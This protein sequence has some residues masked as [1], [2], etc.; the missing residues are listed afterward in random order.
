MKIKGLFI[1][2]F[3][4]ITSFIYADSTPIPQENYTVQDYSSDNTNHPVAHA[5]DNDTTSWWALYN[6]N[7]FS[8]PGIVEINLG[9]S[10]D[11]SGFS[12]LPNPA[13]SNDKAIGYEIYVSEDGI[14]WGNIQ[15]TGDFTWSSSSDVS[16]KHI[17]FGA[18]TGQYVKV[19]YTSSQNTGNNNIHTGDLFIYESD[20]PATGQINQ[21]LIFDPISKKY[22]TDTP[23]ELNASTNSGLDINFNVVSGPATVSGNIVTLGGT[24]GIVVIR[25]EQAGDETYYSAESFQSF[26]VIDLS[27]F[28]PII[29][30]RLTEDY[31]IEMPESH[32]FP[33]Y[34]G[35]SIEESQVL[36]ISSV[37]VEVEGTIYPAFNGGGYYYALWTP[38]ATGDYSV[39]ITAAASNG[40]ESTI[41]KN[42]T[43]SDVVES[44][45]V[46]TM[47]DVVIEF[48]G[49]NSRW[50]TGTY[51]MPQHIGSYDQIMAN[52]TIECP[53]GNCDDWDRQAYIDVKGP[54]GNWI[55]IIRYITPYGVACNHQV[56]VTDYAS[57]LQGEFEIRMF[58]DT[59]GT[60]GWQVTLDFD[61]QQGSPQ[62]L[63]SI[64][65][66]IWD[67]T[68]DLGNPTNLQPV[69]TVTYN[70]N[71]TILSSHMRLSTT[72]HGWGSNNSQNAAEFY[73]A[74][75]YIDIDGNQEYVQDL[76][77]D[78]NPNPDNCTG[79]QGTWQYDRAGWCPGII[80][81]PNIIDLA[82][83]INS[84]TVDLT[85]RFDPTYIDYCH[86]N[87]P[88]CVSGSTCPD[89]NDGY[90]A[91]YLIDGQIVNF[92]NSP[93]LQD[94]TG[95]E[96]V[97][98][99]LIY[100]LE[101]YPNPSSG[102]F[103]VNTSNLKGE[104]RVY[105]QKI[106][107]EV[108]KT[109]YFN[110]S[111]ELNG[112]LFDISNKSTGMYFISIEN[113]SGTGVAKLVVK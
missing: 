39:N 88:D 23:F 52:L 2:M 28:Y 59:W 93:L 35:T 94:V 110:N 24:A 78:C 21:L 103:N 11:V 64:V 30:T 111:Q 73:H 57:L 18:I 29:T 101:V 66:E 76:W 82:G 49:T 53:A 20:V 60:G 83:F 81:P 47:Q 13:N 40:N 108:I 102:R 79:Q 62:F 26:E 15:T 41:T 104:C 37:D 100:D 34:I 19:V 105:I 106:S 38:S 12:Y 10:Y 67:G 43:V 27:T 1:L 16:R 113:K 8:L 7:G 75:N 42:I 89:C 46:V 98:N 4:F 86:P 95:I 70:F 9:A 5:F 97:D 90:K 36:S 33:I 3:I 32:A 45:N 6:A 14:N 69:D 22:T 109:Y 85:Y 44:Q 107:G 61:H 54:D 65:D 80:A 48:G 92:S 31:P 77:N 58:I 99:T 71:N 63:Y 112:Y 91:I 56:D 72:G 84:G 17:Y 51:T 50:Y 87:N 74:T 55:Q 25:A 96:E 68:W